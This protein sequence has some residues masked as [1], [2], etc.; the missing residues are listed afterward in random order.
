MTLFSVIFCL[1]IYI[2]TLFRM[3]LKALLLV[4]GFGK[5]SK[6]KLV[7]VNPQA[8]LFLY[9]P[10]FTGFTPFYCKNCVGQTI[11]LNFFFRKWKLLDNYI[12]HSLPN[13]WLSNYIYIY[14]DHIIYSILPL[15]WIFFV[16][17]ANIV[18]SRRMF[19]LLKTH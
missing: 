13:N 9:R 6:C 7:T 5:D 12:K 2:E 15:I 8:Y 10:I 18:V 19:Q 1:D 4:V 17:H 3:P 16:A 14:F 11:A